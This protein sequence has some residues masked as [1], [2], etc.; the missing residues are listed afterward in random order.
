[1]LGELDVRGRAWPSEDSPS[2]RVV[3]SRD[4]ATCTA[5][6]PSTAARP[7]LGVVLTK[8]V[9]AGDTLILDYL[10]S[11]PSA[12]AKRQ[13]TGYG[14]QVRL[15]SVAGRWRVVSRRLNAQL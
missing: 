6:L 12:G 13:W 7:V 11:T 1:M 9:F 15:L 14:E 2:I 10:V 8:S 4:L 3:A 5:E